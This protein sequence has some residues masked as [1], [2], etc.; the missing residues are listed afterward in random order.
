M[1][2]SSC[3]SGGEASRQSTNRLAPQFDNQITR[4]ASETEPNNT[5]RTQQ[6]AITGKLTV[7]QT[8][9]QLE[10]VDRQISIAALVSLSPR[11]V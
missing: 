11:S 10:G 9:S 7:I 6:K 8:V 2:L 5:D 3:T 1:S 4:T